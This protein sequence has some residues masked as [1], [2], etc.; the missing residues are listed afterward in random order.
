MAIDVFAQIGGGAAFITIIP[1]SPTPNEEV[2]AEVRIFSFETNTA[3]IIWTRNGSV[4][5]SGIGAKTFR[6]RVGDIGKKETIQVT[7]RATDGRE[8]QTIKEFLIGD[9]DLLW[10]ADTATPPEYGGK[11]LASP[12]SLITVTAIPHFSA[13]GAQLFSK[14]VLYE[15]SVDGRKDANASGI[16]K[17]VLH[18]RAGAVTG[19]HQVALKAI[20]KLKN[21]VL[22]KTASIPIRE[23]EAHIY[24][25]RPLEGPNV[26]QSLS[27]TTFRLG[28]IKS[29]RAIP[30]FF[31]KEDS[32]FLSYAWKQNDEE[33]ITAE[34]FFF[35]FH[36]GE[37]GRGTFTI[38][39]LV[40]NT[41]HTIQKAL[42]QLI[43]NVQ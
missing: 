15:W 32:P 4:S 18:F 8:I 24:E 1:S 25:E 33:K 28:D 5:L 42:A 12:F 11:A 2:T 37:A 36:S 17:N 29:F 7:A 19:N 13:G 41:K 34:P 27:Q 30:Y 22:E 21:S 20:N 38:D 43:I 40:K 10:F 14:D 16:A 3:R 39:V 31:P 23:P 6:F 35:L 26:G 9:I